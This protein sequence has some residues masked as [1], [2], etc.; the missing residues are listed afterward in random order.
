MICPWLPLDLP[1]LP[2][3]GSFNDF[4]YIPLPLSLWGPFVSSQKGVRGTFID[5]LLEKQMGLANGMQANLNQCR[6]CLTKLS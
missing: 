2:N 1:R 5:G 4:P 6:L 3:V